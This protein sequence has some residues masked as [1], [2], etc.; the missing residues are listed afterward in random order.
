MRYLIY[1]FSGT[2]GDLYQL[3]PDKFLA[4]LCAVLNRD[5]PGS[6]QV[7]DRGNLIDSQQLQPSGVLRAALNRAGGRLFSNLRRNGKVS[8]LDKTLFGALNA[9]AGRK[10]DGAAR[11]L[12][13]QDADRILS[14]DPQA[15][16]LNLRH[17]PGF[18]DTVALAQILCFKRPD[19]RLIAIGHRASWF[20]RELAEVYEEFDTFVVGPSSYGTMAALARG[21][22]PADLPNVAYRRGGQV[23]STPREFRENLTDGVIPDYSPVS[24]KGIAAQ[25]PLR[26]LVLANEACPFSCYFCPRP[27]TYGT[28]WKARNPACVVD[29][30][31]HHIR[32]GGVRCFRFSDSTPPPGTL[33]AIAR[34]LV[35]RGLDRERLHLS[36]FGRLNRH[37]REDYSLLRSAGFEAMFFGVESG[38]QKMLDD[39]LGKKITV[40][41]IKESIRAAHDAGLFVVASFIFPCP[42]ETE[43]SR[44][45]T[46]DLLAELKPCLGSALIQP[47]GVYPHTPWHTEAARFGVFLHDDYVRQA[48]TYPIEPL[49]PLRFW[50]PFPFSYDLMGKAGREVGFRDIVESFDEFAQKVWGSESHGGLGIPNIQDYGFTLARFLGRDPADF[51]QKATMHMVARDLSSLGG[52]CGVPWAA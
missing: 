3:V 30:I 9:L 5:E 39:A 41:E 1:N 18:L 36:A 8:A 15:V 26:E 44:Q 14:E 13:E 21:E 49:K 10:A 16:F 38:S 29:E 33:S 51:S 40:Q 31:E 25:L 32:Y 22:D 2:A 52:M 6:A 12:M 37:L 45:E 50:R 28:R 24:Y 46:L 48:V 27:L 47:A 4:T 17:G 19:I 23:L 42:G 20:A 11:R 34:E 35:Q 7:W 43:R